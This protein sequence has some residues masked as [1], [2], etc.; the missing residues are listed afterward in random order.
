MRANVR[1][2]MRACVRACVYV[3]VLFNPFPAKKLVLQ[4]V[5]ASIACLKRRLGKPQV[6]ICTHLPETLELAT[7]PAGT[8]PRTPRHRS[9]GG[10]ERRVDRKR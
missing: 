4:V 10:G 2:C 3:C 7:L 8:K 1:A 9:P 5:I 6:F